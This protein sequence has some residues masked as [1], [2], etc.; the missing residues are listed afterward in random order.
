MRFATKSSIAASGCLRFCK[1]VATL[2]AKPASV[3]MSSR[4]NYPAPTAD[5]RSPSARTNTHQITLHCSTQWTTSEMS[6]KEK[7]FPSIT[8]Q[9]TKYRNLWLAPTPISVISM[10]SYRDSTLLFTC[11]LTPSWTMVRLSTKK[12]L[13]KRLK[14]FQSRTILPLWGKTASLDTLN[15]SRMWLF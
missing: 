9:S 3:S 11:D 10:S 5:T 8:S 6:E 7:V 2:S 15:C 1:N 13:W 4:M 14:P 12:P